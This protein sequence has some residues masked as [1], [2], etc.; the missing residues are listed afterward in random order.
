MPCWQLSMS[1]SATTT[2]TAGDNP[3]L[4]LTTQTHAWARQRPAVQRLA[5]CAVLALSGV[6][7]IRRLSQNGY[8][9]IFYSAGVKSMLHSL[10]NFLFVSFDPGGLITIDKPP[11]GLWLQVLSAK[12]F[13]FSP[14]SL[15]LPEALAGVLA[16]AALYWAMNKA[17][18]SPAALVGAL[19]LAV[20]PSF[21]AI[22]RDNNMD[23]LL[24]VLMTVS[25]GL[26][27][28]AVEDGRWRTLLGCAVVVGLAF[29]TK[30]LAAY[31]IVPGIVL[32][33]A[34]CAPGSLPSRLLRL[35]V[36]GLVLAVVSF[37]WIAFVDLTPASQRPYVGGSLDNSEIGLTFDYNGFGRVSGQVGGPGRI[38]V[39]LPHGSVRA[40][41]AHHHQAP[42]RAVALRGHRR[43]ASHRHTTAHA[44]NH[45]VHQHARTLPAR[46]PPVP[47]HAH[48]VRSQFLP[49]GRRR[50]PVAFGGP[51]GPLRLVDS[52]L[53]DQAAW[54]LPFALLGL[55]ALALTAGRAL[56]GGSGAVQGRWDRRD[57]RL[58]G[59]LVL[60]G[61]FAVE[62]AVLS[63]SKGIVHPY[64]VSAV[65]PGAAAM[66]GA[67]A[68]AFT[69][70]AVRRDWRAVLIPLAVAVTVVVQITLLRRAHYMAWFEPVLVACAAIGVLGLAVRR[71]TTV[72]MTLI[73]GA[74][75][76]APGVYAATTWQAPVQ[77][78]F[79]A[80][81]PTQAAGPGGLGVSGASLSV[82]QAL[83]SYV[84]SHHPGRRWALLGDA[85]DTISP[86]I[87]LGL[88]A[89]SL[90]GYS[91]TD[92]AL[93]GPGLARLVARGEARYVVLGGAY[94]SRGGNR[95][96]A[97]AGLACRR[98]P[99]R[100]WSP[101][102][103]KNGF[104]ILFDCAGRERQ[105][106]AS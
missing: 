9:N 1:A 28:R 44:R 102:D 73:L 2:P 32:A 90:G 13:G 72:A 55:L 81:G 30:T 14:L 64:Y 77:G 98:I 56:T 19:A 79:P 33:Y 89:G 71:L 53:G 34:L 65:G 26:A 29:N 17:F 20:F 83:L 69:S 18:G 4:G 74:L 54:M 16:V 38:P 52:E 62:A 24:I 22:A 99:A 76:L 92:P 96:T 27:L 46:R 35:A 31:L 12:L 59:L 101:S 91:G 41:R 25:C 103:P 68:V 6:L 85:S 80:A 82:N 66:V 63:L 67:G 7:N 95:A 21:V 94:A 97:A 45:R 8:A 70:L 93:N 11:L 39:V 78:T 88:K 57:P 10:H 49:N 60:G 3:A 86:L 48:R 87:L 51:T 100:I 37:A 36:A 47:K 40:P 105:L 61:W 104:L 42:K 43:R 23:A 75:L 84:S 58:A 15:L 5:L 106:A 50:H